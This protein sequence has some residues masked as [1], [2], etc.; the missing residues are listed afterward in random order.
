MKKHTTQQFIEKA[1]KIHGNDFDYSDTE[2]IDAKTKLKIKHN[3]CGSVLYVIPHSHLNNSGGSC[4]TCAKE[5]ARKDNTYT[6]EQFLRLVTKRYGDSFDY[7]EVDYIDMKTRIKITHKKCGKVS[8]IYPNSHLNAKS[9]GC[10]SCSCKERERK[11]PKRTTTEIFIK[12][13]KKIYGEDFDYGNSKYS[14]HESKIEIKHKKCG[15]DFFASYKDFVLKKKGCFYCNEELYKK[16]WRITTGSF[17]ERAKNIHGDSFDYSEVCYVNPKTKIKVKHNKCGSWLFIRPHNH[18]S[19]EI[20][21]RFCATEE[22][23]KKRRGD[24]ESFIERARKIHG[25]EFDYSEAY[26]K[27]ARDPVKIIHKSCGKILYVR[28][29]NHVNKKTKCI[30]CRGEVANK[31]NTH[32]SEV[33]T[34]QAQKIHGDKYD[35]SLVDYK[36]AREKVIIICRNCKNTFS[37]TPTNHIS[38]HN[39][40]GCPDCYSSTREK[41]IMNWLDRNKIKYKKEKTFNT[42]KN[43]KTNYKLRFDFYLEDF[44]ALL[45]HHG[46]QHFKLIEY[47]S[48]TEKGL[49]ELQERDLIKK[50]WAKENGFKYFMIAYNEDIIK[51]MEEIIEI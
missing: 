12:K 22:R 24:T 17:I 49:E 33:F 47:F 40:N 6:K 46:K 5:K 36:N 10:R 11:T 38:K 13:S 15:K 45:E 1:K 48:K 28:P 2:Y 34:K 31:K 37:Q 18:L 26:Y 27:N 43:P 30:H 21:C 19:H 44:G 41:I 39:T 29:D 9:E 7:S 51:R 3:I 4:L 20:G 42:C 32:T 16:E 50:N 8:N 25:D 14:D 23:A 35:Y